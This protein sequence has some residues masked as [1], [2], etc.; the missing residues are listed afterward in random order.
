MNQKKKVWIIHPYG[1]L[2]DE[3]SIPYRAS[4]MAEVLTNA[5]HDVIWWVAS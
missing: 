3:K 5:G 2:P 4:M 1:E